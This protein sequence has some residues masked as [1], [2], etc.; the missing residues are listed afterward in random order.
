MERSL[1]RGLFIPFDPL[2][3]LVGYLVLRSGDSRDL[4]GEFAED[5]RRD[6][7][8]EQAAFEEH[9]R[10][11]LVVHDSTCRGEDFYPMVFF[12]SGYRRLPAWVGYDREVHRTRL[13][14]GTP[15]TIAWRM[16]ARAPATG[17]TPNAPGARLNVPRGQYDPTRA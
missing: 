10:A 13:F 5:M 17:A 15:V 2:A 6:L 8:T 4:E 16:V 7:M 3:T 11:R 1:G 9:G 14:R 12:G